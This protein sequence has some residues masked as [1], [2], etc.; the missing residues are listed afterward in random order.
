MISFLFVFYFLFICFIHDRVAV[1]EVGRRRA[2]SPGSGHID[3]QF[4]ALHFI[5]IFGKCTCAWHVC[6]QADLGN[7]AFGQPLRIPALQFR[8]LLTVL[9][10]WVG[11]VP[12]LDYDKPRCKAGTLSWEPLEH[13]CVT[14]H[15]FL[16][17]PL[18]YI[19]IPFHPHKRHSGLNSGWASDPAGPICDPCSLE[20]W[21]EA[22]KR[23]IWP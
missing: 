17:C 4:L 9:W 12:Y 19:S 13:I 10:G 22:P 5:K 21:N 20:I 8:L 23:S 1:G 11:L 6:F 14:Q 7:R 2:T 15:K 3:P 18:T 16:N